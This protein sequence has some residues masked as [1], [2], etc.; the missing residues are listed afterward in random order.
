[1]TFFLRARG[2]KPYIQNSFEN[3]P[4]VIP[5]LRPQYLNRVFFK[6]LFLAEFD[7]I[8]HQ[9][10]QYFDCIRVCTAPHWLCCYF[11][12]FHCRRGLWWVVMSLCVCVCGCSYIFITLSH[13]NTQFENIPFSSNHLN[14]SYRF[15]VF[16]FWIIVEF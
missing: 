12:T 4:H 9:S 5:Y 14:K 2:F 13:F 1:M 15:W 11:L 6:Q 7:I 3:S 16:S 10:F 8:S